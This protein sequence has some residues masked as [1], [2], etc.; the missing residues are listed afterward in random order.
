MLRFRQVK[1]Y[2]PNFHKIQVIRREY[3]KP[4]IQNTTMLQ[5]DKPVL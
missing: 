4:I 1:F 3:I 2:Q 5:Y